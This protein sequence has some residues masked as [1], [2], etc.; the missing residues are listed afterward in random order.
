MRLLL[1]YFLLLF[2]GF[3]LSSCRVPNLNQTATFTQAELPVEKVSQTTQTLAPQTL[4]VTPEYWNYAKLSTFTSQ[5]ELQATWVTDEGIT[6]ATG[7]VLDLVQT[8]MGTLVSDTDDSFIIFFNYLGEQGWELVQI[9]DVDK[10]TEYYFK[11]R[12]YNE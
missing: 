3:I 8:I 1:T 4:V 12:S 6:R 10:R 9:R 7:G 2:T 5:G 11:Q